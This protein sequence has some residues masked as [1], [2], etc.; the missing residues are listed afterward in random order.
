M[1]VTS[2]VVIFMRPSRLKRTPASFHH[3]GNKNNKHPLV[4]HAS[5]LLKKPIK[6]SCNQ[7]FKNK[8]YVICHWVII[9]LRRV[10]DVIIVECYELQ[11]TY[12]ISNPDPVEIHLDLRFSLINAL[13]F[14]SPPYLLHSFNWFS[15]VISLWCDQV[16]KC[17][18]CE[19]VHLYFIGQSWQLHA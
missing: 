19:K 14:R 9:S 13:A 8:M 17:S 6:W 15:T 10:I 11:V 12:I 16:R 5:G 3:W 2:S 1:Q 4:P 7:L 18:V